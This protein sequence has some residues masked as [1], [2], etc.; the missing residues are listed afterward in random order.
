MGKVIGQARKEIEKC[1]WHGIMQNMQA[2][3]SQ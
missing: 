2:L 3:H 1:A